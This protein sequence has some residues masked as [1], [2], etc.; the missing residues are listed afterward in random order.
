MRP[1]DYESARMEVFFVSSQSEGFTHGSWS[2]SDTMRCLIGAE[3]CWDTDQADGSASYLKIIFFVNTWKLCPTQLYQTLASAI[4]GV[5]CEVCFL[6][7]GGD[8]LALRGLALLRFSS[9]RRQSCAVRGPHSLGG[10]NDVSTTCVC[11]VCEFC[12]WSF[13]NA[14]WQCSHITARIYPPTRLGRQSYGRRDGKIVNVGSGAR[15]AGRGM[16]TRVLSLGEIEQ[17]EWTHTQDISWTNR[18]GVISDPGTQPYCSPMV[19]CRTRFCPTQ[20]FPW[21]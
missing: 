11:L 3:C 8:V 15:G 18:E 20:Y 13:N 5:P 14:Q 7:H 6:E 12:V 10:E 9:R 1:R 16:E 17:K 21:T 2:H 19:Y 4:H